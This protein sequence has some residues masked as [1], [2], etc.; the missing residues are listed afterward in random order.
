MADGDALETATSPGLSSLPIWFVAADLLLGTFRAAMDTLVVITALPTMVGDLGGRERA[1]WVLTAYMLS[2]TAVAPL[3]G[4]LG[5]LF[6][7]VKL[8]QL[9]IV[10]FI[11]A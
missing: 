1:S 11:L 9:S 7:R 2:S 8:Y 5:D 4:K 3:F 6:G 10:G